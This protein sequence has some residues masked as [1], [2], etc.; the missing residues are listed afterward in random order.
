VSFNLYGMIQE[1]QSEAEGLSGAAVEGDEEDPNENSQETSQL[2][3]YDKDQD[4]T[5]EVSRRALST[6]LEINSESESEE[7]ENDLLSE[8]RK[9]HPKPRRQRRIEEESE[10]EDSEPDSST[11]FDQSE[12]PKVPMRQRR[13]K[14]PPY[15]DELLESNLYLRY[16]K[17]D[18]ERSL[19]E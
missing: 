8:N 15:M 10:Y 17:A 7:S 1:N 16:S 4:R 3:Q 11:E 13:Y 9:P 6:V 18:A 2:S 19:D 14:G 12:H 5:E